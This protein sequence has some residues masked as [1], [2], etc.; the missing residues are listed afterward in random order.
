MSTH[1]EAAPGPDTSASFVAAL[2]LIVLAYMAAA[3]FAHPMADDFDFAT[4]ARSGIW[5]AWWR[6]YQGWNG[7]YTSNLFGF[8]SPLALGGLAA[9]RAAAMMMIAATAAA[10]FAFIREIAPSLSRRDAL[11]CAL[12]ACALFLAQ[13]PSIG[14]AVYWYT[15]AV[16]YQLAVVLMLVHAAA[17]IRLER[18]TRR[19]R[20]VMWWAVALA[21]LVAAIGCNEVALLLLV[22]A[23]VIVLAASVVRS[24]PRRV[25]PG[26][27]LITA[28]SAAAIV[29]LS[30]GNAAR[31]AAYPDRH[32]LLRSS[33]MTALQT[34]RFES[35]WVSSGLLLLATI[36]FIPL[37]DRFCVSAAGTERTGTRWLAVSALVAAVPLSVFPA[38]WATGILGQ[39]RTLN[40]AYVVFLIGWFI[41][42]AMWI[43]APGGR[44]AG[45]RSAARRIRGPA[46]VLLFIALAL[47]RNSYGLA[48]DVVTGRLTG[49]DR[50]LSARY[51]AL[52][53]C[54]LGGEQ[55]CTLPALHAKPESMFVIDIAPDPKD[56][57]NVAYARYFGVP[58]VQR[59]PVSTTTHPDVR[60]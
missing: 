26:A 21:T 51:A 29:L 39:H 34:L 36:L 46:A 15:S 44:I 55:T 47:T 9:Y 59:A 2:A 60:H 24:Q 13:A 10:L 28:L 25:V 1:A 17:V 35:D 7:R 20:R 23:Y 22:V 56:W 31:G 12:G 5:P 54:R 58:A 48:L 57:V 3:V 53:A 52:D 40:T 16:T 42:V 45:L 37:A 14:E 30:P 19:G 27:L 49:L 50:E 38:Y 18:E 11:A 32:H 6:Q 8:T 41:A 33:A 4:N 43:A